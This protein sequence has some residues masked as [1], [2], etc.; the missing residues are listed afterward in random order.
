MDK[1][2]YPQSPLRAIITGPSNSGKTYFL[3]NLTLNIIDEFQKIYLYSPCLHQDLYQKLILCFNAFLP[4]H[5]IQNILNENIS[6][7]NLDSIINE[8]INDPDFESSEIEIETY[9]SIEEL[10]YPQDY[11]GGIIIL[12]DLNEKEMLDPRIQSMFKRSR[13]NNLSIFIISQDYYELPKRTIRCNG[14]YISYF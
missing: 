12:D 4:L 13:H 7:E 2:L 11:E 1:I 8:L 9:D 10:K 3:S 6:I 14:K 5:V